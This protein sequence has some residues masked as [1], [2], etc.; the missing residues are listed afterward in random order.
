MKEGKL[1]G[2]YLDGTPVHIHSGEYD[3]LQIEVYHGGDSVIPD[4]DTYFYK[5]VGNGIFEWISDD[6]EEIDE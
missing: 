1:V 4:Y 3:I 6:V 2:G 5:H